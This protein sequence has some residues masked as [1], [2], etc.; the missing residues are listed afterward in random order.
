MLNYS[1]GIF[2]QFFYYVIFFF[3]YEHGLISF[4]YFVSLVFL[5]HVFFHISILSSI[6]LLVQIL[7][8][9]LYSG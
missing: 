7:S 8:K 2:L 6:N 5:C 4:N 1:S 3:E 9:V